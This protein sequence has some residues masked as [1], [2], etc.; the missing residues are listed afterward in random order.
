MSICQMGVFAFVG[1][2][3][4][5][6]SKTNKPHNNPGVLGFLEAV[7]YLGKLKGYFSH[8]FAIF[9]QLGVFIKFHEQIF[10]VVGDIARHQVDKD[11]S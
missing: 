11:N 1:A 9:F 10:T 5:T 7:S 2:T 6:I 8:F 4:P 3:K